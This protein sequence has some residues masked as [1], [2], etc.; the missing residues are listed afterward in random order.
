MRI[1]NLLFCLTAF[2]LAAS[3]TG[4]YEEQAEPDPDARLTRAF[5]E[6]FGREPDEAEKSML[7]DYLGQQTG[8][9]ECHHD[10]ARSQRPPALSH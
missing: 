2:T 6:A 7:L 10:Q 8:R 1:I 3:S 5:L 9:G 4:A